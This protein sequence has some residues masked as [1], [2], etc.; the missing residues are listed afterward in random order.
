[1][2]IVTTRTQEIVSLHQEIM[3]HLKQSLEK[4]I[5][6]GQLLME[7]KESL[8]HG[9]FTPW[10]EGNIPFTDRTARNYMR[11]FRER[12][13]IKTE[14]VSDLGDAYRLITN[15]KQLPSPPDY[16]DEFLNSICPFRCYMGTVILDR[17]ESEEFKKRWKTA[18]PEDALNA[19]RCWVKI[20]MRFSERL[21][22]PPDTPCK[23]EGRGFN[24]TG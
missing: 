18:T 3:G 7:Q 23:I 12:D 11:L 13:R 24:F 8:K 9:E 15:Q 19:W 17:G 10:L 4:A 14:S 21:E 20:K 22:K 2:D 6:I 1:M 5:K 16:T